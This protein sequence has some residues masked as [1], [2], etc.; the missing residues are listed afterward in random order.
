MATAYVA[1]GANEGDRLANLERAVKMLREITTVDA[2]SPIYETEP[3]GYTEQPWFLNAA[4]RVITLLFPLELLHELQSI[5]ASLGKATSFANGPRT[6]DLDLLLYDDLVQASADLDVPHPRMHER[7]FVLTPLADIAADAKHPT[8]GKTIG[9]L[10][11]ALPV[12]PTVRK[13]GAA[14]ALFP[15][16]NIVS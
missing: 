13:W 2:I 10:L 11:T 6:L 5:E 12:E 8:L 3:V 4:A 9:E 14:S 16:H 15:G 1:L 7:R